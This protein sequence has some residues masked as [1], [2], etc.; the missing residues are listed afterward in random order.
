M[1][2]TLLYIPGGQRIGGHMN[3]TKTARRTGALADPS[4]LPSL[5]QD[6]DAIVQVVI[7]TPKDSRN[8]YAFDTEQK[9]F[10][11]KK[12]LPAGL[13]CPYDGGLILRTKVEDVAGV[14]VL[15]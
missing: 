2:Y 10:E 15:V 3:K 11:L 4:R 5:D 9:I 12:A 7:E 1:L 14:D 6:D 8:K 13:A